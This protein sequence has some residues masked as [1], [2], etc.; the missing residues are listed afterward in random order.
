[1]RIKLTARIYR[2]SDAESK[3]DYLTNK[4]FD[5][6]KKVFKVEDSEVENIISQIIDLSIACTQSENE[7]GKSTYAEWI[8]QKFLQEDSGLTPGLIDGKLEDENKVVEFLKPFHL[9]KNDSHLNLKKDINQYRT[10]SDLAE[11]IMPLQEKKTEKLE[12]EQ[13]K[14]LKEKVGK[15]DLPGLETLWH[16]KYKGDNYWIYRANGTD[17]KTLDS[18]ILL[19]GKLPLLCCKEKPHCKNEH[20]KNRDLRTA[21]KNIDGKWYCDSNRSFANPNDD[22]SRFKKTTWCTV[23][24][25]TNNYYL[26]QGP[27][28]TIYKNG[29]P[30]AQTHPGSGQFMDKNDRGVGHSKEVSQEDLYE[31]MSNVKDESKEFSTFVSEDFSDLLTLILNKRNKTAN[32]I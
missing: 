14:S 20:N 10:F 29:E 25:E 31:V 2:Q 32:K 19:A 3:K 7:K 17:L 18:L 16:G 13:L 1:M 5:R 9:L 23:T 22:R 30:W 4:Y 28:T 12:T 24:R 26:E 11:A 27:L 21:T 8:I 15:A 6:I